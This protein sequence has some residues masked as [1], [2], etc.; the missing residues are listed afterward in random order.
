M[1]MT[2]SEL[3]NFLQS[4]ESDQ[5]L[6]A[7]LQALELL[8]RSY[9]HNNFQVRS[10]RAVASS[11]SEHLLILKEDGAMLPWKIGDTLQISE[12]DLQ[13][14]MLITIQGINSDGTILIKE[15][16]LDEEGFLV[17]KIHYPADVKMG[18]VNMMKWESENRDKVGVQSETISRHSVTYFNMDQGNSTMGFP[19]SLMGFLKP[20]RKARFG[21]GL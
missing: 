11:N 21:G 9:T 4:D 6:E 15:D 19:T 17:T 5:V 20:Y 3:K 16:L 7:K 13:Q 1:I 18:I 12:S 10:F 14:D 2:V 8:I